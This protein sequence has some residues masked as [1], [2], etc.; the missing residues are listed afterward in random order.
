M[1]STHFLRKEYL[2]EVSHEQCHILLITG[3]YRIQ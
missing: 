2:A 3:F 1:T